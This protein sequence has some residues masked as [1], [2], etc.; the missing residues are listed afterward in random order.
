[1]AIPNTAQGIFDVVARHLL[2][3]KCQAF[4][5]G[6]QCAYRGSNGTKCAVGVLIPDDVYNP[7]M[8]GHDVDEIIDMDDRLEPLRPFADM[9][10]VL[11][12]MH[13]DNPS[14]AWKQP[15][16]DIAE[17]LELSDAVLDEF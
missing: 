12:R 2:T 10:D 4:D 7:Y 15:L 5:A 8:E 17:E 6:G 13:D 3:Q 16:R 11:Q 9:L 14:F 1:M